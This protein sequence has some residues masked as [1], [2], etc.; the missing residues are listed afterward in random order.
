VVL[1]RAVV[2]SPLYIIPDMALFMENQSFVWTVQ[3]QR[4]APYNDEATTSPA[5]ES[6]FRVY[7]PARLSAPS[8]LFPA[9]NSVIGKTELASMQGLRFSWDEVPEAASYIWT[10]GK[11]NGAVLRRTSVRA[12]SYYMS[13]TSLLVDNQDFV[14]TVQA[15]RAPPYNDEDSTSPAAESA[16]RVYIPPRLSAPTD[17]FPANGSVIG[18]TELESMQGVRFSWSAAPGATAYN[19]IL[20][21]ANGAVLRRATITTTSYFVADVALFTANQDFVWTVQAQQE[22]IETISP[23][24]ESAFRVYVPNRLDMPLNL[25]P[26]NNSVI[27]KTELA[28][29]QGVNFS[30]DPVPEAA[31]Y[32]WT[33]KTANGELLRRATIINTSFMVL[34]TALFI[35]N[36]DLIWTVQAR[37]DI[38]YTDET[39]S[40]A[41]ENLLHISLP[42]IEAP[43]PLEP[44]KL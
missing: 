35:A 24:A 36:H 10:L 19:W 21:K 23:V 4:I 31:S 14:W 17:L 1:R 12:T 30:W 11:S 20:G 41:A 9:N 42:R 38:P 27:S 13:D 15:Q 22:D 44:V 37:R 18:K 5:A 33:L 28:S 7:I 29:L 25:S 39:L 34:D 3:A 40:P 26:V 43:I 2:N 32:I 8:D 16:F 6:T